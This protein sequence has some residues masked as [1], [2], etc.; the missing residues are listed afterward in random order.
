MRS[1]WK[2]PYFDYKLLEKSSIQN[3]KLKTIY[4]RS[5]STTILPSFVDKLFAIY[6]GNKYYFIRLKQSYVGYKLGEL[7]FTRKTA[8]YKKKRNKKKLTFKK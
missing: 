1:Y 6:G 8:V 5:R 4:T 2:G 7:A 3:K